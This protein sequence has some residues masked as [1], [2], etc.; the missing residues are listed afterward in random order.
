MPRK[1]QQQVQEASSPARVATMADAEDSLT[2]TSLV[3]ELDKHRT[4]LAAELKKNLSASLETSL[5]P[6]Q[7]SLETIGTILDSH[8]LKIT[9]IEGTLTAHSDELAE[10]TTRVGQLEKTNAALTSKTEDLENRCRR[11]NRRL[12]RGAGGRLA[13]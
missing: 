7:T 11:Q 6:I 5:M 1:K 3:Q 9:T 8:S 2:L 10:L 13:C 12:A 4:S